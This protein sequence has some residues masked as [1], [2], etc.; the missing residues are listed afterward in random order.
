MELAQHDEMLIKK[1]TNS[2]NS[3]LPSWE[4]LLAAALIARG[5]STFIVSEIIL[6]FDLIL[7]DR[8]DGV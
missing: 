2:I 5:E 3:Y 7:V 4:F 1:N 6:V 8:L